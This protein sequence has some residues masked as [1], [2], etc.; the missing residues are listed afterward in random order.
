MHDT[1]KAYY[2][3][4]LS[5]TADLKTDACSTL[6]APPPYLRAALAGVHPTVAERY[7]GCGLSIP[8]H[9]NGKRVLDLG[10]GAGRDAFAI[11]K[12]VGPDGHVTGVDMT[13]E[14]LAIARQYEKWHAEQY[15]FEKPNTNFVEGYLESLADLGLG[16]ASIDVIISNCVINLCTDKK[17]VFQAAFDLL[18]PG[19]E[20]YFADVYADKR[21]SEEL[22]ADPVLYGEC[23][24]GALC[25]DD[26]LALVK[27]VG[28]LDP[29]IASHRRLTINDPKMIEKTD[30]IRFASVTARLMKVEGLAPT[31]SNEEQ[32]VVYLGGIEGA[33]ECL[34]LDVMNG[35]ERGQAT[36]VDN[37][38]F[39]MLKASRFAP[40]F[41]FLT[42]NAAASVEP[43]QT[44]EPDIFA[45]GDGSAVNLNSCCC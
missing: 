41:E 13:P 21:I 2:G 25:W 12:L 24:S 43:I 30:G 37:N 7:Y 39:L 18:K 1:V 16:S 45:E 36:S 3:Q 20:L 40:H 9:L 34:K 4:S 44:E 19:G 8:L 32:A 26:Y 33:E 31:A 14:Q 17:A 11:A 23:L 35:F 15:G 38:T 29:R 27:E 22:K 10:S 28:F 5:S 6:E 42:G